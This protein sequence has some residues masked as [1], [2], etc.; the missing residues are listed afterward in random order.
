MTR[1]VRFGAAAAASLCLATGLLAVAQN[2]KVQDQE[3][4]VQASEVPPP[5]LA[6]LKQLAGGATITAFAEEIEHGHRFYE[7]SWKGP[8]GHVD[9]L[10]TEA[11]A[12]VEIEEMMPAEKVPS[13]VRAELQNAAGKDAQVKIERKTFFVYEGHFKKDGKFREILV[14]PD[15]RAY[16]EEGE[17]EGEAEEDEQED[18]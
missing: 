3:R 7:G 17:E 12:V 11:G 15:G 1:R 18:E 13:V 6:A 5:A 9:G 8:E 2:K 16:Q 10:V 14:T 4:P